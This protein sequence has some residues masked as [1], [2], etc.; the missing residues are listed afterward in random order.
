MQSSCFIDT[1]S[2]TV[3]GSEARICKGD[4]WQCDCAA[5]VSWQYRQTGQEVSPQPLRH[6]LWNW[7]LHTCATGG[8][9][10]RQ[11]QSR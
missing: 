1:Y 8:M 10:G 5:L 9:H 6:S 11:F 2:I 4:T 3:P 7:W